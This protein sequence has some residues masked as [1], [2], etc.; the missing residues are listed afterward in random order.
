MHRGELDRVSRLEECMCGSRRRYHRV[1]G[2]VSAMHARGRWQRG[3]REGSIFFCIFLYTPPGA[4]TCADTDAKHRGTE[5]GGQPPRL[6]Q[7][8]GF[9]IPASPTHA[10]QI[11]PHE[12]KRTVPHKRSHTL[13]VE[14]ERANCSV[15]ATEAGPAVLGGSGCANHAGVKH[16]VEHF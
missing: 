6:C 2:R 4:Y 9:A 8:S 13:A 7:I 16:T 5:R 15:L 11:S 10:K 12:D 14:R 3:K 1:L